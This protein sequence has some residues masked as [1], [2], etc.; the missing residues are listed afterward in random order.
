MI[1]Q[2]T[3]GSKGQALIETLAAMILIAIISTVVLGILC[4][5]YL[6]IRSEYEL[7]EALVCAVSRSHSNKDSSHRQDCELSL[8]K[9][10]LALPGKPQIKSLRWQRRA[11]FISLS[12]ELGIWKTSSVLIQKKLNLPLASQHF[13]F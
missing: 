4:L 2:M 11:H 8:K 10:I 9:N 12:M 6:K 13:F 1:Q 3:E 7:H 5:G